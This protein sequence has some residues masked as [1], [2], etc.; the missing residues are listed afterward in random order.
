VGTGYVL[1]SRVAAASAFQRS[2]G[3][4]TGIDPCAFERPGV[5]RL[6]GLVV[7][8]ERVVQVEGDRLE[9]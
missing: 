6:G 3:T 5:D 1:P 8:T 9:P 4:P 2:V 7:P